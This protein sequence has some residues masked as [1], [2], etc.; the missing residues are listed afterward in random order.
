[1]RNRYVILRHRAGQD[2]HWDLMLEREGALKTFRLK[3]DPKA[4]LEGKWIAAEPIQDHEL[5]FLTYEGS[6]QGG[7]GSVVREAQGDYETLRQD[8]NL[9]EVRM[10][11][12]SLKGVFQ[13]KEDKE[14]L[15][16]FGPVAERG[17]S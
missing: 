15:Q 12:A 2:L 8:A 6:V 4:L 14:G 10:Q 7:K 13:M 1:M 17:T 3:E 16:T 11:G 9:W 5:R